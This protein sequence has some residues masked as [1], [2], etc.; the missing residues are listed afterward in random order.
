MERREISQEERDALID[1]A[2][3][4]QDEAEALQYVI[5]TVPCRN[6]PPDGRSIAEMLLLLD[7]AQQEY[8]RPI[9]QQAEESAEVDTASIPSFRDTF[10]YEEDKA[11][12][13]Q[14]LLGK[15][16]KHRAALVTRMKGISLIDWEQPVEA[17]EGETML[18]DLARAMIRFERGILKEIA[19][20]V[21]IFH[22]DKQAHR[23]LEQR[24]ADRDRNSN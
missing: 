22:Q 20:Q 16:A 3:W 7:H 13:I 21:R 11:A 2:S 24:R 12:D 19:E 10:R 1:D 8:Y 18:F 5:D 23:E 4:L 15:I 17:G 14:K 9:Y 6:A